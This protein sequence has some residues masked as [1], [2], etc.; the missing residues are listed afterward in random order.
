MKYGDNYV[1]RREAKDGSRKT[2]FVGTLVTNFRGETGTYQGIT[3]P[4]SEGKSAKVQ[5]D[6]REFY[7]EVWGLDIDSK[8]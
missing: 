4:P 3:R 1:A 2:V 6:G 8:A 5:V 7:A